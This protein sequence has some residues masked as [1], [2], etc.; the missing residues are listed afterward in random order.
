M[1]CPTGRCNFKLLAHPLNALRMAEISLPI[2]Q[3]RGELEAGIER[4]VK[5]NESLEMHMPW[6]LCEKETMDSRSK[7]LGATGLRSI[8]NPKFF[9]DVDGSFEAAS[10]QEEIDEFSLAYGRGINEPCAGGG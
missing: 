8:G 6:V 2:M 4:Y 7:Q 3:T 5:V 1:L 9:S 10:E